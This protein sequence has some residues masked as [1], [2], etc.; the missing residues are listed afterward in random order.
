[1]SKLYKLLFSLFLQ[2]AFKIRGLSRKQ[3]DKLKSKNITFFQ[4][5]SLAVPEQTLETRQSLTVFAVKGSCILS[6]R[7]VIGFHLLIFNLPA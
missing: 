3:L 5:A 2:T 1:M 4:S 7:E 6:S